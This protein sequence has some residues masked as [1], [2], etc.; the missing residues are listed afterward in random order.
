[1]MRKHE[2]FASKDFD[3]TWRIISSEFAWFL[4]A[5]LIRSWMMNGRLRDWKMEEFLFADK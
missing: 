4:C 3:A 2:Q 5:E 1:M